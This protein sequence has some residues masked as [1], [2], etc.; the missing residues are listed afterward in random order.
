VIRASDGIAD[1]ELR[2]AVRK[3]ASLYL[4][5]REER[6]RLSSKRE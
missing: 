2:D 4:R 5:A 6:S 3:S 1:E